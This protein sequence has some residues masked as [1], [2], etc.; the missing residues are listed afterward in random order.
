VRP[1]DGS[2]LMQSVLAPFKVR[3][4]SREFLGA[5][6]VAEQGTFMHIGKVEE[7]GTI[8]EVPGRPLSDRLTAFRSNAVG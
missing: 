2:L 6:D 8:G 1:G 4:S 7:E 3:D 5:R